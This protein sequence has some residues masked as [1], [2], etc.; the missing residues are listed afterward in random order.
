NM[1]RVRVDDLTGAD[2][3]RFDFEQLTQFPRWDSKPRASPTGAIVFDSNRTGRHE[4]WGLEPG[5][6]PEQ[7]TRLGGSYSGSARYAHR[8]Q[9]LAFEGRP[10][11]RSEIFMLDLETDASAS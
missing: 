8:D 10:E 4:L 11:G 2:S 3:P 7:L 5:G 9:R 6:S 1:W